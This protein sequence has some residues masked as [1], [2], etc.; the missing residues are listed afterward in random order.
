MILLYR[1]DSS[2]LNYI[3]YVTP[4]SWDIFFSWF[5]LI[6]N[7]ELITFLIILVLILFYKKIYPVI[8]GLFW[9]GTGLIIEVILKKFWIHSPPPIN[10]SRTIEIF[11]VPHIQ[12]ETAYSFPSGHAYRATFLFIFATLYFLRTKNYPC[13]LVSCLLLLIML[14]SRVSLAEHWPSDVIGG[15]ILSILTAGLAIR[16]VGHKQ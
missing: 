8:F 2:I 6:G 13:V 10:L 9:Y 12:F 7:F 5:S 14:F 1:M 4:R 11:S 16:L 3:Q 15:V